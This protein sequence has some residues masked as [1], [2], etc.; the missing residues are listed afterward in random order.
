MT[1]TAPPTAIVGSVVTIDYTNT[2]SSNDNWFNG[3]LPQPSAAN[4]IPI[5]TSTIACSWGLLTT[6]LI[7]AGTITGPI[8]GAG[9]A[10]TDKFQTG[11][12]T[13]SKLTV[14]TQKAL[15]VSGMTAWVRKASEIPSGWPR[16]TLLDGRMPVG[17]GTAHGATYDAETNY[18]SSWGH[19]HT[20]SATTGQ[21]GAFSTN[22]KANQAWP[23]STDSH[24]HVVSG[25]TQAD[26]W[27]IPSRAFVFVRRT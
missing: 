8:V 25:S 26:A 20:I 16:E 11:A 14:S 17:V 15:A 3:L 10:T 24:T 4:Q 13:E 27:A 5:S 21:T 6:A 9:A 18:G 2:F 22:L 19:S 12:V 1:F 7:P 23:A